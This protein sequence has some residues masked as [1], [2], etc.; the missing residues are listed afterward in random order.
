MITCEFFDKVPRKKFLAKYWRKRPLLIKGGVAGLD[1]LLNK[2]SILSVASQQDAT[3][4]LIRKGSGIRSWD[5][6]FGPFRPAE[7]RSLPASNWTVLVQELDHRLPALQIV[8]DHFQVTPQWQFDDIMVSYAVEG[9]GVGPHYDQYDVFLIQGFGQ[10]RWQIGDMCDVNTELIE[11]PPLKVIKNFRPTMEWLCEP[12]DV[13]YLP[14]MIPHHGVAVTECSTFSV[15]FRSVS[16]RELFDAFV[17]QLSTMVDDKVVRF[18]SVA[19]LAGK[20][21]LSKRDFS[22]IRNSLLDIV[23]APGMMEKLVGNA[24]SAQR[25]L[26]ENGDSYNYKN[27]QNSRIRKK[28]SISPGTRL[29]YFKDAKEFRFF[30]NGEEWLVPRKAQR[31]VA[32]LF[33]QRALDL[34]RVNISKDAYGEVRKTL[35]QFLRNGIICIS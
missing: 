23:R 20:A 6:E 17:E 30:V 7:F 11:D 19:K 31:V 4:R 25:R 28:V 33:D 5:L 1:R 16:T 18:E 8:R 14:P 22:R 9:G 13:L 27:S 15:G 2:R 26:S 12:G 3:S 29:L 32:R 21:E 35:G 24:L 10:R 34:S